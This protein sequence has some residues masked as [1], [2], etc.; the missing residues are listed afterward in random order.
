VEIIGVNE[1]C[2]PSMDGR[3]IK[4]LAVLVTGG[5]GDYACYV[6]YGTK[7]WVARFGDK[8]SFKHASGHFPGGQLKKELYRE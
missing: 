7:E 5:A 2:Y 4:L 8:V 6:G 1:R 3:E